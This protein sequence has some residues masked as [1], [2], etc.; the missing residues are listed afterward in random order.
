MQ[1]FVVYELFKS[2]MGRGNMRLTQTFKS[3]SQTFVSVILAVIALILILIVISVA[4]VLI[5][6]IDLS[7]VLSA[8]E[9]KNDRNY[10]IRSLGNL[11]RRFIT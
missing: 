6:D 5:F 3:L 8:V 7:C 2:K 1:E 9:N 4:A 11:H 10:P